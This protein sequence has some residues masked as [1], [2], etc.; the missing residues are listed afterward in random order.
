M[1]NWPQWKYEHKEDKELKKIAAGIATG[2]LFT[3]D[4][5]VSHRN[6]VPLVFAGIQLEGPE[7]LVAADRESVN[8]LYSH[9]DDRVDCPDCNYPVYVSFPGLLDAT[10]ADKVRTFVRQ[11]FKDILEECDRRREEFNKKG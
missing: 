7:F 10:D 2:E 8:M 3:S 11:Y 6:L 9:R 4:H 5:L 1:T